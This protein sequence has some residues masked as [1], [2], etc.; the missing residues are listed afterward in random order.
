MEGRYEGGAELL[1][2]EVEAY[3][4]MRPELLQKYRGK[5]VAVKGGR[6][7]GVYDSEV[8]ALRDA[9]E[10][11]GLVPVLIR[12]VGEERPAEL[13][14]LLTGLLGPAAPAGRA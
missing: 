9:L 7:V 14:N 11:F 2:D 13:V 1:K 6:L 8:E 5:V 12:R 3:E 4:R 10:R